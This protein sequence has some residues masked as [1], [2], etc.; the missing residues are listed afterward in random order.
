[1]STDLY[2]IKTELLEVQ[3]LI[4]SYQ[5]QI[6]QKRE[7]LDRLEKAMTKLELAKSDFC[8]AEEGCSKPEFT[9]KSFH[10]DQ[11][12]GVT[13]LKVEELR[14]SFAMI[15]EEQITR[16]AEKIREQIRLLQEQIGSLG[17][18]GRASGRE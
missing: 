13:S 7:N 11:A 5:L 14:P 16:I 9:P 4:G 15:S 3:R 10:G 12:K 1:M 18:I 17:K 2:S 6:S 8:D